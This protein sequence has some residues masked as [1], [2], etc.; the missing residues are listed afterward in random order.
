MS[1]QSQRQINH[2][3]GITSQTP[4]LLK[5]LKTGWR[6][7]YSE[8][9]ACEGET[10]GSESECVL[11]LEV[12][13]SPRDACGRFEGR[14]QLLAQLH[15]LSTINLRKNKD[16]ISLKVISQSIKTL[17]TL[18][19]SLKPVALHSSRIIKNSKLYSAKAYFSSQLLELATASSLCFPSWNDTW[20]YSSPH[21]TLVLSRMKQPASRGSSWG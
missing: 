16:H 12:E 3:T 2:Q 13:Q 7:K 21:V 1:A 17:Y 19:T 9:G 15:S 6:F 14:Q 5:G 18:S 20:A 8:H 11:P 10:R 4:E